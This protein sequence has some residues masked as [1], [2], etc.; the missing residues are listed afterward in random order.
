MVK[1]VIKEIAEVVF[2]LLKKLSIPLI[3][4]FVIVLAV[5]SHNEKKEVERCWCIEKVDLKEAI[6]YGKSLVD[7][8]P[9]SI[10]AYRCL[11]SSYDDAGYHTESYNILKKH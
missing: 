11:A 1:D 6:K 7:K 3:I 2:F 10:G 9:K 4:V 5:K 8:Y